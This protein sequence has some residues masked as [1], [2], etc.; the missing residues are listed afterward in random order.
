MEEKTKETIFEPSTEQPEAK[1]VGL[2]KKDKESKEEGKMEEAI[3]RVPGRQRSSS[4][5]DPVEASDFWKLYKEA[6]VTLQSWQDEQRIKTK[7]IKNFLCFLCDSIIISMSRANASN[8]SLMN[9]FATIGSYIKNFANVTIKSV[10][11]IDPIIAYH[12]FTG[13][14]LAELFIKLKG[15]N[16]EFTANL[17]QLEVV[18]DKI[19]NE[20]K[21]MTIT[22][23]NKLFEMKEYR[24][25]LLMVHY[26]TI[27]RN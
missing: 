11:F 3:V 19:G 8:Q 22:Y 21:N 2:E 17:K 5:I 7:S 13:K 1:S 18:T 27:H 12:N 9:Y 10:S 4:Y 23:A 24:P 6:Y 20:L 26:L 14:P 15:A 16:T 25:Q